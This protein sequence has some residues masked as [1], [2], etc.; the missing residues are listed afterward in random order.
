MRITFVLTILCMLLGCSKSLVYSPSV[1]LSNRPLKEKE[2]DLQGGVELLPEARPETLG[3]N[4]TT[5]GMH[6]QIGYGFG[7]RF[8][9]SVKG[10]VDME[11]RENL[12]RT[13]YSLA[14]QFLLPVDSSSRWIVLPRIGMALNGSEVSGYGIGTSLLYQQSINR[15]ISWYGG[16]GLAWGFRYLDRKDL[17]TENEE[18]LPMGLG[19][20]GNAGLSWEFIDRLRLNVELSP[21][22]QLNTFDEN[23][24]FL[25][26]P[27]MGIGYTIRR[28]TN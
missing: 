8:N 19:L 26:S 7:N 2:I 27:A 16:L 1:H 9:M 23:S 12:T 15:N 22:Y 17:N 4:P 5:L 14:G 11:G 25:L 6:G 20:I 13:G 21:I 24:Q 3:G 18:K 10:W 28:R